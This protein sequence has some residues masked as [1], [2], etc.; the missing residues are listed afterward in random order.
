LGNTLMRSRVC[1]LLMWWSVSAAAFAAEPKIEKVNRPAQSPVSGA[2]WQVLEADG[3]RIDLDD[4]PFCEIWLRKSVPV[5]SEKGS[6]EAMFRELAPST[7]LGIINFLKSSTDYKGDPIK[8]GFYTLRFELLP[9]DG[10][11]LGVAP[12]PDFVLIMPAS[13]SDPSAKLKFQDM[14]S[15]S[16][17]ATESQHPGPLSLVQPDKTVPGISKDDQDHWVFSANI[18]LSSGSKLAVGLVVKGTA[19]Q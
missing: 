3:F 13:D 14:V 7:M 4:G 18:M 16:R 19:P 10:N 11:H 12:N 15:L 8:P 5:S 2:V 6:E 1:L 9:A 17:K